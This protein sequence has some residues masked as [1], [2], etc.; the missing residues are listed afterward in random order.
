MLYMLDRVKLTTQSTFLQ[1]NQAYR[2]HSNMLV[3]LSVTLKLKY[4]YIE[5]VMYKCALSIT[6]QH[7]VVTVGYITA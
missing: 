2:L 3:S 1:F 6:S 4:I 7:V 5:N